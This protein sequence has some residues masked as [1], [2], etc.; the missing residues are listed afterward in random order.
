MPRETERKFRLARVPPADILGT[1]VSIRQGYLLTGATEL[2]VRNKG[3]V[4]YLTMKTGAGI[5]RDEWEVEIPRWVFDSLWPRV[6]G[7][8]VEKTRYSVPHSRWIIEVDV[9]AGS[10]A[11]LVILECEF[12]TEDAAHA[13]MLP[14]WAH[15]ALEVTADPAYK[16]QALAVHGVPT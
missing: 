12:A 15:P 6:G 1:G 4:C 9:Y 11:G 8:A 16:N 3:D 2:R 5:G 13:F 7:H 10:L 14:N